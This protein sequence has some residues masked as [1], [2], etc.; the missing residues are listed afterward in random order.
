MLANIKNTLKDVKKGLSK[1]Y[2]ARPGGLVLYGS[3]ARGNYQEGSDL[4][5]LVMESP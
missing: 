5:I 2:G 3:Y 1:L 4:D